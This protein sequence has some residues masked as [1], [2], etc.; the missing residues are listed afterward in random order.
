MREPHTGQTRYDATS[1]KIP[2]A[3]LGVTDADLLERLAK[4]PGK[5]PTIK[6]SLASVVNNRAIGW[7]VVGDLRG[8]SKPSEIIL[9]G[10]HLDSWD[11]G[12][13]A[14]DDGAGIAITTA[15]GKLIADLPSH[16]KRTIRVVMFGSEETGGSGD[17]YYAAHK[18]EVANTIVAGESDTGGDEIWDLRL[19]A[20]FTADPR[21][22]PIAD[23]LAPLKVMLSPTPVDDAG[24]DV[25]AMVGAGVPALQLSQ[26]A[27]RYF[28]LHHSA[29]D[30]LDKVD[31]AK[32]K[33]NVA[34]WVTLIHFI[35][36]SDI[37]FRK[38]A[39]K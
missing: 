3:A 23:A 32:L 19:P 21:L 38:P 34:A 16:P 1:P 26:N 13:G 17:A 35:A 33:Q 39:M 11:P 28:D 24:A 30:T 22:A 14:I 37:D 12:E 5:A 6:L 29:S 7:N 20:G 36:D 15:V 10:G 27:S 4:R 25:E 31:P 2:A 9:I 8:S 18:A